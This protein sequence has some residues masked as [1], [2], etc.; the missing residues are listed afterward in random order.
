MKS[1]IKM[2]LFVIP[3][4]IVC[5]CASKHS[6]VE[7]DNNVFEIVYSSE[8]ESWQ[9]IAGKMELMAAYVAERKGCE[10]FGKYTGIS[11]AQ[12]SEFSMGILSPRQTNAIMYKCSSN[13]DDGALLSFLIPRKKA[14]QHPVYLGNGQDGTPLFRF[15]P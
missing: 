7:Y 6:I 14:A 1:S 8:G 4:F 11:N 3:F 15:V 13:V 2:T 9:T 12:R 5:S 10:W